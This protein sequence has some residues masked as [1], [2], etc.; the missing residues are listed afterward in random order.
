MF[1]KPL[2]I[3]RISAGDGRGPANG[4]VIGMPIGAGIVKRHHDIRLKRSN[5]RCSIGGENLKRQIAQLPVA[6]VQTT[7]ML[8]AELPD[9]GI[10]LLLATSAQAAAC[11]NAGIADLSCFAARERDDHRLRPCCDV[12]GK[13]SAHAE[14]LVVRMGKQAKYADI[15]LL[16]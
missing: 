11:R 9:G 1:R 16:D 5:D 3:V 8:D 7:D 4:Y 13:C 15:L 14:H 2:R 10:Q 12:L 6:I